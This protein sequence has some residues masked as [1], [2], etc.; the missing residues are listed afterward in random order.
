MLFMVRNLMLFCAFS[1]NATMNTASNQWY[2]SIWTFFMTNKIHKTMEY[3]LLLYSQ[4]HSSVG[5]NVLQFHKF[6]LGYI[7]KFQLYISKF[8]ETFWTVRGKKGLWDINSELQEKK[9]WIL[10]SII[11]FEF[12]F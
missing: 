3:M 11:C 9:V 4:P 6:T 8:W 12:V 2:D 1:F 7:S 5:G 10:S